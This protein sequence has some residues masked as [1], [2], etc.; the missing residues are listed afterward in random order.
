MMIQMTWIHRLLW[1][2]LS[3]GGT[4]NER[5]LSPLLQ[6]LIDRGKPQLALEIARI[7][8]NWYNVR[9]VYQAYRE[10]QLQ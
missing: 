10:I 6:W 1:G 9:G 4:L 2:L 7:F 8:L 3:L 5:S